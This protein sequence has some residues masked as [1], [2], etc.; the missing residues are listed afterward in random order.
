MYIRAYMR[1]H[2]DMQICE[3]PLREFFEQEIYV[4]YLLD[5]S[6]IKYMYMSSLR[7]T[8]ILRLFFFTLAV[9]YVSHVEDSFF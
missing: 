2:S 6:F 5:I 3:N 9:V 8:G 7:C 4:K 1:H